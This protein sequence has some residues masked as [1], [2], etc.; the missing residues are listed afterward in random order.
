[1]V[2]FSA[3][4]CMTHKTCYMCSNMGQLACAPAL[5]LNALRP[6][7]FFVRRFFPK[8]GPASMCPGLDINCVETVCVLR[9]RRVFLFKHGPASMCPG[10]DIKCVETVCVL[11]SRCWFFKHGPASMCPG[12]AIKCVE[13]VCVL[14]SRCWFFQT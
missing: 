8:H 11:R 3:G 14:R 2:H 10:L 4:C 5:T 1:M 9:S 6:C 12:L 7:A 13:S